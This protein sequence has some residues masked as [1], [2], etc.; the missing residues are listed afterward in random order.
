MEFGIPWSLSAGFRLLMKFLSWLEETAGLGRKRQ[1]NRGMMS[2]TWL[3]SGIPRSGTSLCCRLVGE[4]TDTVALSEPM[5]RQTF[6]GVDSPDEAC[7]RIEDFVRRARTGIPAEGRAPSVQVD[8]RLDDDR[9]SGWGRAEGLRRTQGGQGEI[10]VDKPLSS[11]FV[12]L[13]KHNALFAALL[14]SL[15]MSTAFLALVRNPL[16]VLASWQ[17]VD[18]PIN[19]G[20]IPAGEQYDLELQRDLDGEGDVLRRQIIVLN[21]FFDRFRTHLEPQSILRYEDIVASGGRTLFDRLG[22]GDAP[23]VPL[24]NRNGNRAY[25]ST[26]IGRLLNTLV[27][28]SGAWTEFYTV[29][30]CER[31]AN[32]IR[33]MR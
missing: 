13:I 8:G 27:R 29:T 22:R 3:L 31:V 21:W 15:A 10:L 19:R 11:A 33:S 17:T 1:G 32:M 5:R 16:A 6:T 20:R 18:L 23:V 9:V 28:E 12:L 14:P 26:E 24:E 25:A 2:R 4:L 30:D 7:V